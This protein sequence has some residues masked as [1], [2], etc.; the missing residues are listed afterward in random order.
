MSIESALIFNSES[1]TVSS[2]QVISITKES[3]TYGKS[4][5]PMANV[6]GIRHTNP[7]LNSP[8]CERKSRFAFAADLISAQA[9]GIWTVFHLEIRKAKNLTMKSP[10]FKK[11]VFSNENLQDS[12]T[13]VDAAEAALG[14][15]SDQRKL[16][17]L[18]NPFG[19]T[20]KAVKVYHD[21]VL[22]IIRMAGLEDLHE[23]LCKLL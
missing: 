13:I 10:V 11:L 20:N 22:P 4:V 17:F 19:G 1:G 9:T 12:E 3:F 7:L 18:A 23:L 8:C 21:L 16:L 15:L 5:I 6:I 2:K 14:Y